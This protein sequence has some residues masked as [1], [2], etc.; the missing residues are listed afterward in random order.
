MAH[1]TIS[2]EE[3][4]DRALDLFRTYGYEGVSLS[5][6]S[7]ATGL[8]KASLY[9][10]YPG[11]KEEIVMAVATRVVRWFEEYVFEPL[12]AE[13]AP[14]KRVALVVEQLRNLYCDG[15]KP[16]AI[17][18]LSIAGG[19]EDLKTVLRTVTQAWV[20]AFTEIA[21]ESG[22]SLSLAR[23]RAEEAI[24]RIEGSLVIVRA[25]GDNAPFQRTLKLLPSLL[26]ER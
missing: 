3:F 15:S 26:T 14:R 16:C 7:E 5:R 4:L 13:S 9:Y 12:K 11:G 2:D 25:L 17:D 22:M 6:L 1:R 24:V 10:R 19:G 23:L 21:Q 20:K 18:M 8:E